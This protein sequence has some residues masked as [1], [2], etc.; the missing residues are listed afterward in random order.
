ME[1]YAGAYRE[2]ID[3]LERALRPRSDDPDILIRLG[4]AWMALGRFDD[5]EPYLQRAQQIW[6]ARSDDAAG[7]MAQ[8]DLACAYLQEGHV[9]GAKK[10][11]DAALATL[12]SKWGSDDPHA[13]LALQNAAGIEFAM[14]H[15]RKAEDLLRR[16]L[17]IQGKSCPDG[18]GRAWTQNFL[19]AVLRRRGDLS[20]AEEAFAEAVDLAEQCTVESGRLA[21]FLIDLASLYADTSRFEEAAPRFNRA[22][23]LTKESTG[24]EH[25]PVLDK[26][27]EFLVRTGRAGEASQV[28][29]QLA[30]L[31]QNA[32]LRGPLFLA[33]PPHVATGDVV[34]S[35]PSW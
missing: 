11:N 8:S 15:D 24:P 20:D 14:G 25:I 31:R 3:W 9:E 17:R 32:P 2:Q 21:E 16:I 13:A 10:T 29:A 4:N 27:R 6:A 26:Y 22:L 34:T 23:L 7:A 33:P 19:G 30:M 1:G 12:E 35:V 5:A 18:A 28:E